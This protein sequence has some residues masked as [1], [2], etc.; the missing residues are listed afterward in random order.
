MPTPETAVP[1][2]ACGART[3]PNGANCTTRPALVCDCRRCAREP[4]DEKFH[5]CAAH[6]GEAGL[7]H[8]RIRGYGAEWTRY[9]P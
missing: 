1:D 5:A 8:A 9:A 4:D 6:P 7:H 2:I 3:G